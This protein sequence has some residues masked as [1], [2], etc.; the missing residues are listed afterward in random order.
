MNV[1]VAHA[2]ETG[3][4]I[5]AVV[6]KTAL[7]AAMAPQVTTALYAIKSFMKDN[8]FRHVHQAFTRFA[9]HVLTYTSSP[10]MPKIHYTHYPLR[11]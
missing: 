8:A 10:A 2:S 7:E 6:M 9:T 4:V 11:L 5:C 3:M 1:L